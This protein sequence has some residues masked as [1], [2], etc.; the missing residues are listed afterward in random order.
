[1][2]VEEIPTVDRWLTYMFVQF[3]GVQPSKAFFQAQS[4]GDWV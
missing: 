2:G 1:L 3:M 4:V